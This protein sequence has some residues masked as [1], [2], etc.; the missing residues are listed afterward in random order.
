MAAQLFHSVA[1][2]G[3]THPEQLESNIA[4]HL[5][6]VLSVKVIYDSDALDVSVAERDPRVAQTVLQLLVAA[7]LQHHIKVFQSSAEA[8]L[9]KSQLDRS[10]GE[11]H[12][13]LN[14]FSAFM[15]AHRVYNDDSQVNAL[16]EQR[17]KLKLALNEVQADSDAAA[18]RLVGCP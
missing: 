3:E 4:Q 6:D 10:V 12:D 11:Y 2:R 15:N 18:A 14:E 9:L 17:E 16:I 5:S 8:E 13:R 7:Y 1:G